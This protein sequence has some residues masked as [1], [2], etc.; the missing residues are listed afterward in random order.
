MSSCFS[1]NQFFV[2]PKLRQYKFFFLVGM[3]IPTAY[4]LLQKKGY[5]LFTMVQNLSN[6]VVNLYVD[7]FWNSLDYKMESN[8]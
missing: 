5:W 6:S 8:G 1:R 3:P 4:L 2:F 7:W